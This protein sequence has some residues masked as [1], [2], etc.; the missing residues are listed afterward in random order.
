[1]DSYEIDMKM[2]E[3]IRGHIYGIYFLDLIP[4]NLPNPSMI[5]VNL[6]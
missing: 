6:D 5:I 2:D 1:M 3:Q 4:Q